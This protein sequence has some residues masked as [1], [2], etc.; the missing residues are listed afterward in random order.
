[1]GSGYGAKVPGMDDMVPLDHPSMAVH[2]GTDTQYDPG[3]GG[4]MMGLHDAFHGGQ[5]PPALEQII[6][7]AI[8][9]VQ[10]MQDMHDYANSPNQMPGAEPEGD[11]TTPPMMG[12]LPGGSGMAA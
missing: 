10:Q 9:L 8:A 7:D 5:L 12:G 2:L 3:G 1:M 6:Q 11:E 4:D